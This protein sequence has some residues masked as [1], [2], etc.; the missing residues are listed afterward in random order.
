VS[1]QQ[2]T[3]RAHD[4]EPNQGQPAAARSIFRAEALQHYLANQEKVALPPMVSPHI[5]GYLWLAAGLL[6]LIGLLLAFWPWI[7]DLAAG[8]I[9][10][11]LG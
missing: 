4:E 5:F 9:A 2:I 6:G 11:W 7:G 10:W 8:L 1:L 3:D